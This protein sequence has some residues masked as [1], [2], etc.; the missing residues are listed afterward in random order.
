MV[1]HAF[2]DTGQTR[3]G[4][5][6]AASAPI[7]PA[8][9]AAPGI[10]RRPDTDRGLLRADSVSQ[11]S[12]FRLIPSGE[13]AY[14]TLYTLIVNAERTLDLQYYIVE[15]DPYARA[16]LR[17]ARAAAERGVRVRILVDDMYT[18]GKDGLIVWYAA[19]PNIQVRVF[20]AFGVG[21]PWLVA[22]LI[23]SITDLSR[24]NHRMHNKMFVADNAFAVTGGRNMGAQ[25]YTH[26][27]RTNFLDMDVL[28]VGPIVRDL[29]GVF[30]QYWNSRYAIPIEDVATKREQAG[31]VGERAQRDPQD[32]V[33]DATAEAGNRGRA[34]QQ[35]IDAGRVELTEAAS[36]LIA[37]R[38]SKVDRSAPRRG[39]DGLPSGATIATDIVSIAKN[40]DREL[41][42][43]SPYFVPGER[44]M[45]VLRDLMARGVKV[46]IITNSL[47]ATDAAIVCI[48]Y[49]RYRE[50]LLR[51]G[52]EIDE[53]RP[54]PGR[55]NQRL[56][57]VG[58]SKASLH[59]KV[60]VVDRRT[61]F[62]GS[63][64]VD[65]RSAL[66]NTEMGIE[67]ASE[68]LADQ[69]LAR[70][71]ERGEASRYRVTLDPDGGLRWT[72]VD[73]GVEK[74]YRDEPQAGPMLKLLLKVLAPFAPEEML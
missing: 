70:V 26:S 20:N 9:E 27:D 59:A 1:S 2:T 25:Y 73:D 13:E 42:I 14:A 35:Q 33:R 69:V 74:V 55:E 71:R 16:L 12:G 3:L 37:D 54:E 22:R 58:S 17:A 4:R 64:N 62:I 57:A 28:A 18:A 8:D 32:A 38:P 45:A 65:Q 63:F 23:M 7:A 60:L 46:H 31:S 66:A 24:I 39:A 72:T 30:D 19:H 43:V 68:P 61:L 11:R 48:G 52:A 15:D 49:A 29:S 21:R 51:L 36:V 56:S 47:A 6:A 53:L 10:A 41:L 50:P 34:L 40:A 44:G 5:V 67:I